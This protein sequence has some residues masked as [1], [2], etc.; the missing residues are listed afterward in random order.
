MP[1]LVVLGLTGMFLLQGAWSGWKHGFPRKFTAL[2][3]LTISLLGSWHFRAEIAILL[4]NHIQVPLLALE[5]AAFF[6]TFLFSY[7]ILLT[8]AYTIFKKTKDQAGGNRI[9]YA[10]GGAALGFMINLV[11]LGALVVGCRYGY[12][13]FQAYKMVESPERPGENTNSQDGGVKPVPKWLELVGETMGLIQQTPLS[14]ALSDIKPIDPRTLRVGSKLTFL[15]RNPEA[16]RFFLQSPEAQELLNTPKAKAALND[17]ELIRLVN[18]KNWQKLGNQKIILDV[19][20]SPDTW[21]GVDL[22][23]LEVAIDRAISQANSENKPQPSPLA[24]AK[25]NPKPQTKKTTDPG[26]SSIR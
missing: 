22:E 12:E 7:L 19:M 14:E 3:A 16:R 6:Y 17:P 4:E 20:S 13:C 24:P 26:L 21:N 5:M 11:I 15:T 25:K 2:L 8:I 9:S 1:G 23:R 18:E 10:A